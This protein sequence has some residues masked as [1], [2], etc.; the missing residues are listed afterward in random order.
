MDKTRSAKTN[1]PNQK[2]NKYIK[3][4]NNDNVLIM[5]PKPKD[6]NDDK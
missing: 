6:L 3:D 2:L 4:E 5:K 1:Q